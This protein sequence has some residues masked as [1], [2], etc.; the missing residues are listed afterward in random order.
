MQPQEFKIQAH[1]TTYIPEQPPPPDR[2][3]SMKET[4]PQKPSPAENIKQY[5]KAADAHRINTEAAHNRNQQPNR[6]HQLEK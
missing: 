5:K 2:K 4:A 1:L 3:R 6:A